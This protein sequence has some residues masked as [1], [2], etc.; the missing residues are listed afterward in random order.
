M[1]KTS[2][3]RLVVE[4]AFTDRGTSFDTFVQD[5]RTS[6]TPVEEI[7]RQVRLITGVPI[8]DRTLYRWVRNMEK[9]S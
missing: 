6:G 7:A 3:I 8:A 1:P 2:T 4:K 9:A 5:L